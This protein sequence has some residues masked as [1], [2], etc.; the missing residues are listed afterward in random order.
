MEDEFSLEAKI[1]DKIWGRSNYD[2]GVSFWTACSG[3]IIA[4]ASL[5]LGVEQETTR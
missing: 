5:T 2:S 4:E 3:N 1:Y